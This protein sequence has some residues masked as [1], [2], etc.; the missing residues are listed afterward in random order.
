MIK[1][2]YFDL[3]GVLIKDFSTTQKWRELRVLMGTTAT[4][5]AKFLEIWMRHRDRIC[6]DYDVDRMISEFKTELGLSFPKNFSFLQGFIN[7][8]K[9]NESIWPI[10]QNSKRTLKIGILTN[11]YPRMFGRIREKGILPPVRWDIILD[12]SVIKLKK[13][14]SRLFDLAEKRAQA[15]GSEV[16]FIDNQEKHIFAAQ[17]FGWHVFHYNS[18][19]Y[20]KSSKELAAY[21]KSLS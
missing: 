4:N 17:Q 21:L 11:M 16:L 18:S 6:I 15:K 5:D 19:D 12:S 14:D 1:F 9:K 7:G 3:G 8:F 13:P 10:L 20:E 2:I